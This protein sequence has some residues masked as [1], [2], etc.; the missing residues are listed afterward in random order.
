MAALPENPTISD[1]MTPLPATVDSELSLA[2]AVDRMYADNIRHLPVVDEAGQLVGVVS[3][4]DIAVAASMRGVDPS[5]AMVATAMHRD[6]FSA[7]ADTPLEEII[8]K[9]EHDR[10]G[11]TMVV[12]DGKPVGIFTTTDVM[13]ALRS[14]M[15]GEMVE[16]EVKPT[17]IVDH[18][19]ERAAASHPRMKRTGGYSG[20]VSWFLT[21]V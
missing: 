15:A 2:D 16:P 7:S 3:T 21:S 13:R 20:M 1:F 12:E 9:M 5:R 10:L 14:F 19:E 18:S 4:R 11:S 17:H 6:P 8:R